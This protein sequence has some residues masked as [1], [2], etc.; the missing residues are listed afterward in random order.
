[1]PLSS[2]QLPLDLLRTS[3]NHREEGEHPNSTNHI[4]E[5]EDRKETQAWIHGVLCLPRKTPLDQLAGNPGTKFL[6]QRQ[7]LGGRR[8]P[9]IS[10]YAD[11]T[12]SCALLC[13]TPHAAS[14]LNQLLH[15]LP[16]FLWNTDL[17]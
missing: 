8:N 16:F 5:R 11:L 10:E 15:P 3:K 13:F 4:T 17:G 14:H 12:L 6:T 1:M 2:D 9:A 7:Q